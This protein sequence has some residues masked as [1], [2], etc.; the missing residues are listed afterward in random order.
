MDIV[1]LLN[2]IKKPA[3]KHGYKRMVQILKHVSYFFR[4][5][6]IFPHWSLKFNLWYRCSNRLLSVKPICVIAFEVGYHYLF[7]LFSQ[8]QKQH[9]TGY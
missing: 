1:Q 2:C 9:N 8:Q 5:S 6:A 4:G 3:I 7:A